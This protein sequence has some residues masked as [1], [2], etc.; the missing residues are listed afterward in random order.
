MAACQSQEKLRTWAGPIR[1]QC[2]IMHIV[3]SSLDMQNSQTMCVPQ[4]YDEVCNPPRSLRSCASTVAASCYDII[5]S[6]RLE[7]A[8]RPSGHVLY[9]FHHISHLVA[10]LHNDQST[11]CCNKLL[12][13]CTPRVTCPAHCQDPAASHHWHTSNPHLDVAML[14]YHPDNF[15]AK[16]VQSKGI[17]MDTN[18]SYMNKCCQVQRWVLKWMCSHCSKT[19][20][21]SVTQA[22]TCR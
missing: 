11:S 19:L 5:S 21:W 16:E 13:S 9:I 17:C 12:A 7:C 8:H 6:M 14:P 10:Q 3:R 2:L 15:A 22:Q 20:S 1:C 18:L 4:S